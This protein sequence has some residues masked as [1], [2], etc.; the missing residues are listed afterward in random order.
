MQAKRDMK[1]EFVVVL[2]INKYN[3]KN[4]TIIVN[5]ILFCTKVMT[6]IYQLWGLFPKIIILVIYPSLGQTQAPERDKR[7]SNFQN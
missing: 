7:H 2:V 5:V 6:F 4:I 1:L 3:Y